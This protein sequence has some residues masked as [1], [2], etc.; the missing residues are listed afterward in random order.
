MRELTLS[1][2]NRVAGAGDSCS[3]SNNYGG[4]TEPGSL[5]DDL[6][7]IYEGLVA[8]TSHMIER[9]ASAF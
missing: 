2:M 7:D 1:E 6:I 5:G 8:V 9:I 4:V 3:G